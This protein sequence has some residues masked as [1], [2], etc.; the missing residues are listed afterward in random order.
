MNN[1][2]NID[3]NNDQLN[4]QIKKEQLFKKIPSKEFVEDVLK[5]FIPNGFQDSY[6]QFSRKMITEKN[7][8]DKLNVILPELKEYYMNC[9][10]NKYLDNIDAKKS[11]T[12]LR[13]L[14][15]LYDYRVI[16]MEKYHNG[17]KFL[18]YKIE[19]IEMEKDNYQKKLII[20]FD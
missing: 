5:L 16:S 6:Y 10:H 14:L 13:Q 1:E 20:D 4:Q 2:N 3:P 9:K 12:I 11:V 18:L 8:I 7:V 15:R 19:K 17:Q